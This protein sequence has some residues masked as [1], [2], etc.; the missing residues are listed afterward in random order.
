MVRAYPQVGWLTPI[1]PSLFT[2]YA[3]CTNP[4]PLPSHLHSSCASNHCLTDT[5][6]PLFPLPCSH[7]H[8]SFLTPSLPRL[9]LSRTIPSYSSR[10]R[11]MGVHDNK[12]TNF[13]LLRAHATQTLKHTHARKKRDAKYHSCLYEMLDALKKKKLY[14][15]DSYL[16]LDSVLPAD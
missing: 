7:L 12:N 2:S 5:V 16:C 8:A 4:L 3:C 1:P 9:P 15:N 11:K 6:Y 14:E 13:Y 10:C